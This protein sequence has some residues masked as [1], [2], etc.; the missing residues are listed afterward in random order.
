MI[1]KRSFIKVIFVGVGIVISLLVALF[2][3]M[4]E[5]YL[6]TENRNFAK[7]RNKTKLNCLTMPLH[8]L[9]RDENTDG[10]S[11]Y[12]ND[13][14]DLEIKDNWGRTALF[15]AFWNN[16]PHIVTKLLASGAD[17]NTKDENG[18]TIFH[19]AVI[20]GKYDIAG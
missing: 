12:V 2:I 20:W 8:C 9:V 4:P 6:Y 7:L 16:K 17:P 15:W 3:A 10:I 14:R 11:M 1:S 19:Q 18:I 5:I 13:G